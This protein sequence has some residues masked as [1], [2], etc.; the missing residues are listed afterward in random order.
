MYVIKPDKQGLV[1]ENEI[2]L[3]EGVVTTP[4]VVKN[5]MWIRGLK[6]LYAVESGEN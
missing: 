5:R 6:H 1:V 4:A 3:Q 2:D